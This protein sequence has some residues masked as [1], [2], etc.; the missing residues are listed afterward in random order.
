MGAKAKPRTVRLG[1]TGAGVYFLHE[2]DSAAIAATISKE[3]PALAVVDSVNTLRGPGGKSGTASEIKAAAEAE[4]KALTSSKGS[5]HCLRAT[6][7]PM[8]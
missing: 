8:E 3:L 5:A 6:K 1:R 4:T 7:V 2:T